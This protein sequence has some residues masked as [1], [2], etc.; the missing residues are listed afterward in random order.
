MLTSSGTDMKGVVLY[1]YMVVA[2]RAWEQ[3]SRITVSR[4]RQSLF[5]A[6]S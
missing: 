4:I 3:A 6:K 2:Q 1:I 5:L